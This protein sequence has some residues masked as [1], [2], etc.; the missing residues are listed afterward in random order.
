[1]EYMLYL[2][3]RRLLLTKTGLR[4]QCIVISLC[5]HFQND[6]ALGVPDEG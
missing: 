2:L 1:M 5:H 4:Q 3:D 6:L